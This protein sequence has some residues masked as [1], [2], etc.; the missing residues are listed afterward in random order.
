MAQ[1]AAAMVDLGAP[2]A[3]A[4]LF[5]PIGVPW[6]AY[7]TAKTVWDSFQSPQQ[8]EETIHA[9]EDMPED[10]RHQLLTDLYRRTKA[11]ASSSAM[12]PRG[13]TDEGAVVIQH[14]TPGAIRAFT[15]DVQAAQQG[16]LSARLASTLV[17]W[18]GDVS[19]LAGELLQHLDSASVET[20]ALMATCR[21]FNS[22]SDLEACGKEIEASVA[23]ATQ[24]IAGQSSA[25]A[26]EYVLPPNLAASLRGELR[27]A[28]MGI[29]R[30]ATALLRAYG[31]D[32]RAQ[33]QLDVGLRSMRTGA[34]EPLENALYHLLYVKRQKLER[35]EWMLTVL[36][37]YLEL[38]MLPADSNDRALVVSGREVAANDDASLS[39]PDARTLL[40]ELR[41]N[42]AELEAMI[43]ELTQSLDPE[44][45][46]PPPSLLVQ[47]NNLR[48]LK[49]TH[50]LTA[51]KLGVHTA[52]SAAD[53]ALRVL[54]R[55]MP[56][57]GSAA[58]FYEWAQGMCDILEEAVPTV[59]EVVA[60]MG[61]RPDRRLCTALVVGLAMLTVMLRVRAI[62]LAVIPPTAVFLRR[63]RHVAQRAFQW[64]C[65]QTTPPTFQDVCVHVADP[66]LEVAQL[67]TMEEDL[68]KPAQ[69][70]AHD[71]K[72]PAASPTGIQ[73]VRENEG[74]FRR[75]YEALAQDC[76]AHYD[77]H[78]VLMLA[79]LM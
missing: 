12:V 46:T 34:L 28:Y 2:M 13:I 48:K 43:A 52:L 47:A 40:A 75:V 44:R 20:L 32:E 55:R 18:R 10:Q 5:P 11:A 65:S 35:V 29:R 74:L 24:W 33:A 77:A 50:D 61:W 67:R 31:T 36:E 17:H 26:M 39:E 56:A 45:P 78:A 30:G 25:L 62:G 79:L 1:A 73:W 66:L 7:Y 70:I 37:G 51:K 53:A 63:V 54:D 59:E 57:R 69:E 3:A 16:S 49:T 76:K 64:L 68:G 27:V 23:W 6:L 22:L 60:D 58:I 19:P 38:P 21:G 72:D 9:I 8:L 42:K 71:P 14:A 4:M 41:L 15:D